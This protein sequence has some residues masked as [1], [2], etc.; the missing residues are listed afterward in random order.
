MSKRSY[1]SYRSSG[2]TRERLHC[3]E[4]FEGKKK[5]RDREE[6]EKRRENS[7]IAYKNTCLTKGN[8]C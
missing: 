1:R 6:I 7:V 5:R 8:T 2:S 3:Q 4:K